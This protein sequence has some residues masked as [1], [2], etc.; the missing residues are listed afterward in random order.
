MSEKEKIKLGS[1]KETI[2]KG[3]ALSKV[4]NKEKVTDVMKK[5]TDIGE[6]ATVAVKESTQ[7]LVEKKREENVLRQ[8]KKYNPLFQDKYFSEDFH[9]PNM[10]IIVDDAVRRGIDVCQ[11]AIGWLDKTKNMEVLYMYDEF[12]QESGIE[13]VPAA[14]CDAAY[15]VDHFERSKFVRVDYIF[16]KA[17]EE[18]LAELK[19]IAYSLGAKYCSIEISEEET[20]VDQKR[21]S[22]TGG[23]GNILSFSQEQKM[24]HAGNKL[25]N[26]RIEVEFEG[27]DTP[28]VPKLKWFAH[29]DNIKRLIDMRCKDGNSVKTEMLELSGSS[30][31]TMS[32]KTAVAIDC[33]V[34]N[35]NGRGKGSMESQAVRENSSKLIFCIGF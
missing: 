33:A 15:Y 25:R 9:I 27:S 13:F 32:Q 23:R 6:K 2:Q 10:I 5:A 34:G 8:I 3:Q 26:G 18:R 29:D 17:H 21:S 24:T 35:L 7:A 31:S 16:G 20:E 1:L 12:V 11:G 30:S 22:I 19:H 4:I 14:M 28:Q